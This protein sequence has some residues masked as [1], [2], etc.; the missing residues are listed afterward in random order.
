MKWT[1]VLAIESDALKRIVL[2][3]IKSELELASVQLS[4]VKEDQDEEWEPY[5]H[6][7]IYVKEH[8]RMKKDEEVLDGETLKT[9]GVKITK[10][11][12]EIREKALEMY[13]KD[14]EWL[15]A[16]IHDITVLADRMN[17]GY[18]KG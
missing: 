6:P 18:F 14:A 11:R 2:P 5:F 15:E 12:K 13:K 17:R 1:R 9:L 3:T 7:K 4:Q 10:F 8:P 16:D